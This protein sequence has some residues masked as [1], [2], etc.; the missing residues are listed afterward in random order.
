M[1]KLSLS[2]ALFLLLLVGL[3]G[4]AQK[5]RALIQIDPFVPN[6]AV[7]QKSGLIVLEGIVDAR[8]TKRVVGRIV[9]GGKTVTTLY[10]DQAL[11]EWFADALKK[12]LEVEGCRVVSEMSDNKTAAQVKVEIDYL[13]AT[14]D[15]SRFTGENLTAKAGATLYI[16]QGNSKITKHVSLVQSKWVPPFAGEEEVREYLQETL[17]GL[18]DEI[19][20]NIDIYRF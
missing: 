7:L 16:R 15:K 13:N 6:P 12:A 9:K 18:V 20:N 17:A 10:T 5:P 2:S 3:G 14:L 1:L 19:R 8:K 4:C 11:D